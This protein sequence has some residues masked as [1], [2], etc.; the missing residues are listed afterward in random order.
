MIT[1]FVKE[2]NP[3]SQ[4]FYDKCLSNLQFHK[5]TCSCNHS[6]CLHIH[7]YYKRSI[8]TI[9][10]IHKIRIC[11]VKC[12]LCGHTHSLLPSSIIPYSQL[13]LVCCRYIITCL[14]AGSNVNSV[15]NYYPDVDENNVK[16]VIRK[17]RKYW[18]QKLIFERIPLSPI[19]TLILQ[20]FANYSMQFMQIRRVFNTVIVNTT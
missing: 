1:F 19:K 20:C 13:L 5:L 9:R 3:L 11:R 14:N 18:E 12:S 8:K 6:G 7:G 10:G 17:Y 2:N 15:C 4:S 16:S